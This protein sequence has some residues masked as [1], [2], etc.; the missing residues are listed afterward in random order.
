MSRGRDSEREREKHTERKERMKGK[1]LIKWGE[2]EKRENDG[3][4]MGRTAREER[5]TGGKDGENGQCTAMRLREE[6]E[7]TKMY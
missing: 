5:G 3:G 4:K 7:R 2:K 6:N 1:R